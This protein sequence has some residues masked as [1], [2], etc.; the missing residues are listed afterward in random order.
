MLY[1][2]YIRTVQSLSGNLSYSV[3]EYIIIY[4]LFDRARFNFFILKLVRGIVAAA[5]LAADRVTAGRD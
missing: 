3:V 1:I 4:Y 2:Y 5:G